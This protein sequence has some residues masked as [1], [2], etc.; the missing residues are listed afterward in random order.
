MRYE[1]LRVLLEDDDSW[2]SF[3]DLCRAFARA[4]VPSSVMKALRLG[5]MTAS[6]KDNGKV[7]GIVAGSV[8]RR[9][10][11]RAV[12]KHFGERFLQATAPFQ[13]ALQTRAGADALI[14]ALRAI[15]DH[16]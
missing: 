15:T 2:A 12:A 6:Q 10:A 4:D 11:C 14:F 9:V 16:D 7:R 5:R 3:V 8:L 13:F 1:H